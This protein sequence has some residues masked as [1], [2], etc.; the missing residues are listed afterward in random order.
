[1][2]VTEINHINLRANRAMMDVL[3]DFYCDIV[4]LK[5]GRALRRPATVFGCILVIMMWCI[6]L[7][8]TRG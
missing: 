5:L 3:R 6:L 4:G 2:P 7:N 1:M 8:T